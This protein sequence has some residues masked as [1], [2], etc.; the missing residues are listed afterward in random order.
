VSPGS[1]FSELVVRAMRE[2]IPLDVSL[3]LTNRCNFRCAHCYIP[4]FH[5][6]DGLATERLFTLLD[7]L[8]EMGTLF[9]ALTGGEPLLRPDWAA[10]AGR[11]RRLGFHVMLLTN[12]S[13]IDEP[14]AD[15]IAE[16][17]LQVH[18]SVHGA[19]AATFRRVTKRPDSFETVLAGVE[20]LARRAV[21]VELTVPITSLNP[22][23]STD[24]PKLARELGVGYRLYASL[25][26]AKDG[27]TAPLELRLPREYAASLMDG[28][29]TG[30]LVPVEDHA[31][32]LRNGPLCAAGVRFAAI[33]ASGEVR[34]CP[35]LPGTAGNLNEHSF[36]EIWERSAWL[37]TLRN[38]TRRD[39]K[40]CSTC[41]KLS[42]CGRCHAVA[43]VEDGDLLGPSR[44]AC[45]FADAVER[46]HLKGA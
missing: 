9:L 6:P 39:L 35:V 25:A 44:S 18:V 26:P 19:D 2:H 27:S 36:R 7:E 43:M 32:L 23:A 29:A 4:D 20:R 34:A 17:Q 42:Y 13:L 10:I 37:N 31:E 45:D 40:T 24:V 33:S 28:P 30:C 14:A 15:L 46:R 16:L 3:E 5:V 22:N 21:D 1:P 12:G 41:S 38:T 8:A 11:A